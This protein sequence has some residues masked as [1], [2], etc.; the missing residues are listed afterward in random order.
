MDQC[1]GNYFSA[2]VIHES[3]V[4]IMEDT[5]TINILSRS[6]HSVSTKD[7]IHDLNSW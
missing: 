4:R 7:R 3:G 2:A 1:N 5:V 6:K